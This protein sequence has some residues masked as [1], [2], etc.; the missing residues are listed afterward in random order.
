MKLIK[1]TW[2]RSGPTTTPVYVNPEEI[3]S[4]YPM[5][6]GVFVHI[7]GRPPGEAGYLVTES[8]DEVVRLIEQAD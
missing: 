1:L 4:F 5:N 8:V 6:D 3:E 7:A 2:M